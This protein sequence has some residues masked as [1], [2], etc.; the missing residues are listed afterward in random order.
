[1]TKAG[2]KVY[3]IT[4]G[5][6]CEGFVKPSEDEDIVK[7][8]DKVSVEAEGAW[9]EIPKDIL[10]TTPEEALKNAYAENQ[11]KQ[12]KLAEE[13]LD[14]IRIEAELNLKDKGEKNV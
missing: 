6:I 9:W 7:F 1:M 13:Y 14:L 5:R 8:L 4:G 3:F 2:D 12:K 11:T 10:F